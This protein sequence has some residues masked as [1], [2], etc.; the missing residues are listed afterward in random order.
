MA[1][2]NSLKV[3][4]DHLIPRESLRYSRD[5]RPSSTEPILRAVEDIHVLK[6]ADLEEKKGSF[7]LFSLLRKPD[8]QRETSAWSP[9][10]CTSL[11]ESIVGTLIIPSLIM[12][13]SP[14]N[15][16]LYIL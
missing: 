10:Q 12:W 3:H 9:E 6:Y 4:L 1:D 2:K 11:L 8:F 5:T 13:E 7:S 16:F 15:G 14:D